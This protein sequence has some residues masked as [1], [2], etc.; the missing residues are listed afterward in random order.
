MSNGGKRLRELIKERGYTLVS[1]AR[2][3]DVSYETMRTWN[4]TA[5]IDKLYGISGFTGIPILE[6]IECF[7]PDREP[8]DT[9]TDQPDRSGGENN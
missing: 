6:I 9:A 1:V 3:I 4:H 8:I 2:A 5:P 7:N